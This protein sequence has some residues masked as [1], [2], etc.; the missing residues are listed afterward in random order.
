MVQCSIDVNFYRRITSTPT[1]ERTE[2]CGGCRNRINKGTLNELARGRQQ[3]IPSEKSSDPVMRKPSKRSFPLF[4]MVCYDIDASGS[5]V[6]SEELIGLY[7]LPADETRGIPAD[8][9]A[10]LQFGSPS[11]CYSAKTALCKKEQRPENTG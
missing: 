2:K 7:N 1:F 8:D 9:S 10:L 5:F 3:L 4:F 6:T 11:R